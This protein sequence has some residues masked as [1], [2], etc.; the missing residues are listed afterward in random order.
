MTLNSLLSEK[1]QSATDR[2]FLIF[3]TEKLTF[4]D[5]DK[6]VALA[7]GGLRDLGLNVQDRAAMS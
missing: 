5:I 6:R 3:K 7:S 2:V 4:S 1:A